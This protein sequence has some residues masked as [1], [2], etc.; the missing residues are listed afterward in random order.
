M[1]YQV[2]VSF[3]AFSEVIFESGDCNEVQDF[4]TNRVQN[5]IEAERDTD[6]ELSAE[7]LEELFLN[8]FYV[9]K[10]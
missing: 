8:D 7:A 5:Y 2:Q 10:I 1:V 9:K 4:I 3:G 6:E